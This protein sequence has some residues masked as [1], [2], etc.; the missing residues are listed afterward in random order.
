MKKIKICIDSR[1]L[2]HKSNG[3]SRYI[4]HNIYELSKYK[5]LEIHLVSN[6]EIFIDKNLCSNKIYIHEDLSKRYLPGTMWVQ[7][8]IYSLIKKIE[9]DI[10]W[11]T[12]HILPIFKN[13]NIK[14]LLT[15]HDMV[16]KKF[17]N[18]MT[19]YNKIVNKIFFKKS[20]GVADKIVCVSKSTSLDLHKYYP[21]LNKDK[22]EIIY[23]GGIEN[24]EKKYGNRNNKNIFILG[25][26]EPRK[27]IKYIL[28]IMKELVKID[29]EIMLY[30]T[31]AQSWKANDIFEDINSD[32]IRNN[33]KILGYISDEEINYYF[34]NSR[35]FVFPSLYEGFGLPL[36]EASGKTK[37]LV[38]DIPVFK[39]LGEFFNNLSFLNI[40][41]K[42]ENNIHYILELLENN[43]VSELKENSYDI[44]TWKFS[45]KKIY[46]CM[47]NLLEI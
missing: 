25:S 46:V 41:I 29:S 13:N 23:L 15:I 42:P 31:G 9:P 12:S 33:V 45:A 24:F 47:H 11:G 43:D 4:R 36:I 40:N 38:S 10:Y 35:I 7:L 18:T 30:L 14:Y 26:L 17:P 37:I 3:I 27:N 5:N 44:F 20:I 6:K 1:A 32:I 22:T 21:E 16:H 19:I 34:N 8:Y 28:D 2:C 39:E